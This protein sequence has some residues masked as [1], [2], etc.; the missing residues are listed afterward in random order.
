[1]DDVGDGEELGGVVVGG[2]DV[3]VSVVGEEDGEELPGVVVEGV[4]VEVGD[5]EEG[6]SLVDG[7]G[8]VDG[9]SDDEGV[10]LVDGGSVFVGLVLDDVVPGGVE[11]EE[12][13]AWGNIRRDEMG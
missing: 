5:E 2:V 11:D 1:M 4:D 9:G 6:G 8:V 3:E 10:E 12:V 13:G 7:G